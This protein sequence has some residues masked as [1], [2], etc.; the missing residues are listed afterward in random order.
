MKMTCAAPRLPHSGHNSLQG[1]PTGDLPGGAL[2][3]GDP[4]STLPYAVQ[5]APR[6]HSAGQPQQAA[7]NMAAARRAVNIVGGGIMGLMAA[8]EL[9]RREDG[10]RQR[11][12]V[13]AT[14]PCL[15]AGGVGQHV[16]RASRQAL[17]VGGV[18]RRPRA[19]DR[20]RAGR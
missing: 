10:D 7:K 17:A 18:R 1:P 15:A 4:S 5:Y 6:T 13:L 19:Q 20:P 12:D 11:G 8:I 3:G 14:A 2:P 9:A 16:R